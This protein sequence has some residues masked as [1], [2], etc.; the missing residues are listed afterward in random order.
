MRMHIRVGRVSDLSVIGWKPPGWIRK[1]GACA[2]GKM[3]RF[4]SHV[5]ARTSAL[6]TVPKLCQYQVSNRIKRSIQCRNLR[7]WNALWCGNRSKARSMFH[8]FTCL[9]DSTVVLVMF[10]RL[11]FPCRRPISAYKLQRMK[12]CALWETSTAETVYII[13][14]NQ[15]IIL[16]RLSDFLG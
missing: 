4:A 2:R 1:S 5:E 16:K 9:V 11:C 14:Y 3:M 15:S 12:V 13:K 6:K 7:T 8:V 10:L